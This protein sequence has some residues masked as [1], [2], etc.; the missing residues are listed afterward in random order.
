MEPAMVKVGLPRPVTIMYKRLPNDIRGFPGKLL[1]A[2]STRLII[3]SRLIVSS[4]RWVGGKVI[5]NNGYSAIWFV[6]KDKWYDIGKFYDRDWNWV[7][8]YCDIIKPVVKLLQT[9]SRTITLTDLYLDLWIWPDGRLAIL[10]EDEL[11]RSLEERYISTSLAERARTE[12][13]VLI[14]AVQS[15]KFSPVSV[16]KARPLKVA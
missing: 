8:Y 5:A 16:R 2:T 1:S 6:Y 11:R 14:K 10:D 15:G 9:Q 7:G 4:R 12:I 3:E 13:A